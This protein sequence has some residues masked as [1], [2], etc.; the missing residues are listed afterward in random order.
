MSL[1]MGLYV[2]SGQSW[3]VVETKNVICCPGGQVGIAT[4][5][6]PVAAPTDGTSGVPQISDEIW[7]TESIVRSGKSHSV[8]FCCPIVDL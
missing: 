7:P 2:P 6:P 4:T 5:V 8:Q 3:Q 1:L